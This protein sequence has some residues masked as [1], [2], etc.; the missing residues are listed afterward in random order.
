MSRGPRMSKTVKAL[1]TEETWNN[2]NKPR[3]LLASELQEKI[4]RLRLPVPAYETIIKMISNVRNPDSD[5]MKEPW[6]IATLTYKE[7]DTIFD[8]RPESMPAVLQVWRYSIALDEAFTKRQAKWVSILYPFFT[9]ELE[10][11]VVELWFQ[12]RLF[13][14][15]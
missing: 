2:P 11:K 13:A 12:S 3:D 10:L 5:P 4:E 6:N 7:K 8:L 1:V 14:R 15:L 9:G